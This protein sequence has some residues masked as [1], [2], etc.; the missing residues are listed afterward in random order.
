MTF[1]FDF[2]LIFKDL[3]THTIP[4]KFNYNWVTLVLIF[5]ACST[6][7]L[8]FWSNIPWMR[9]QFR[10]EY[11]CCWSSDSFSGSNSF[12]ISKTFPFK[13]FIILFPSFL[14]HT[15]I[16]FIVTNS[17][18]SLNSLN[19]NSSSVCEL[20]VFSCSSCIFLTLFSTF[21]QQYLQTY[22]W[23]DIIGKNAISFRDLL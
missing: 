20:W 4:G 6:V 10:L 15:G 21:H 22:L 8:P 3:V 14:L 7:S 12:D 5:R 17:T 19:C 23:I 18:A 2:F 11:C 1:I 13:L 9:L 16:N